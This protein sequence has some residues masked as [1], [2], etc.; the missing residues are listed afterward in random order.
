MLASRIDKYLVVM[1]CAAMAPM[2]ARGQQMP[3]PYGE[4]IALDVARKAADAALAEGKKNGWNVAAAVVDTHGDPVFFERM[5][6]TQYGSNLVAQEKA[7]SAALFKR[8]TKAFEDGVKGPAI[9]VLGL[10]GAL[11]LEGGIPIVMNGKIVGAIGVSG[12]TSA[13]DG[14]CASAGLAAIGA[15]PMAGAHPPAPAAK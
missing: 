14:Q 4:S 5:D 2:A 12:A 13:Q 15:G 9:N 11:P 1:M 3:N 10:P 7:R 8:P 6:A